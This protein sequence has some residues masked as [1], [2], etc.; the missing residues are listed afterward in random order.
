MCIREGHTPYLDAPPLEGGRP[1]NLKPGTSTAGLPAIAG[2]PVVLH[3]IPTSCNV[4]KANSTE[5]VCRWSS[6]RP[7]VPWLRS[8]T[9]GGG[10]RRTEIVRKVAPAP[11]FPRGDS[12]S[13][14]RPKND[15]NST[16]DV[17]RQGNQNT[18]R[19]RGVLG[20]RRPSGNRELGGKKPKAVDRQ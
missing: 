6:L 1:K 18:I 16:S 2:R 3:R 14:V 20:N 17:S 9:Q 15:H 12:G 13:D 11:H 19:L 4:P 5:M 8:G 10:S 7:V